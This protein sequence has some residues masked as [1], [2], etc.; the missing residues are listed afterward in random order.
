VRWRTH[1]QEIAC[2]QVVVVLELVARAEAHQRD[3]AGAAGAGVLDGLH[4]VLGDAHVAPAVW[5]EVPDLVVQ[6][7]AVDRIIESKIETTGSSDQRGANDES[8]GGRW[9]VVVD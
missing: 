6:Q 4:L 9:G 3:A 8:E 2:A 7:V 5:D 1:A